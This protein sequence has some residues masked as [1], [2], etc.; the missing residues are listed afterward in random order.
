MYPFGHNVFVAKPETC[1]RRKSACEKLG[2]AM[3]EAIDS[4]LDRPDEALALLKKRFGAVRREAAGR[5]PNRNPQ[6]HAAPRRS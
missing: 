4:M 5:R 3:V 1:E 2:K 6:G